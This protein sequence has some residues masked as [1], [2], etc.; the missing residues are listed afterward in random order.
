M[1][2]L[3]QDIGA[4]DSRHLDVEKV[5]R[6]LWLHKSRTAL[7]GLA[8]LAGIIGAW[9][10]APCVFLQ[11]ALFH[12]SDRPRGMLLNQRIRVPPIRLENIEIL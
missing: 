6:D 4:F 7:V 9:R 2:R 8:I 11:P 12:M 1:N 10:R 5:L 3:A